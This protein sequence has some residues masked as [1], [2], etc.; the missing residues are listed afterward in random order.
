MPAVSAS[1]RRLMAMA[2]RYKRGQY[3][4]ASDEV[5]K[6]AAS[7]TEDRLEDFAKTHEDH[8]P[9]HVDASKAILFVTANG[10][11]PMLKA[12]HTYRAP[13]GG[14]NQ[15]KGG[16]FI[17]RATMQRE[18]AKANAAVGPT[19]EEFGSSLSFLQIVYEQQ[20]KLKLEA[21]TSVALIPFSTIEARMK[22]QIRVTYSRMA[23]LGRRAGGDLT[24]A[25]A[26][27]AERLLAIRRDEYGYL[28]NFLSDM[29]TGGGV[30]DYATRT[31]FYQQAAREAYWLGWALAQKG[32]IWWRTGATEHCSTCLEME[33]ASPFTPERFRA[34]ALD[35]GYLPQSGA[36]ECIGFHCQCFLATSPDGVAPDWLEK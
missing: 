23:A 27:E 13:A 8:L 4:D 17:D 21:Q 5:K 24:S 1:Q 18:Q 34:E 3:P 36:L 25:T 26:E 10:L 33:E 2:L 14:I 16:Q 11:G 22:A 32:E 35:K 19:L 12:R 20:S 15:F 6:L 9:E 29:R 7:M 31:E 28:R 30:M